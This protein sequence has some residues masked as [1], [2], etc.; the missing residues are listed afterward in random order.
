MTLYVHVQSGVVIK[1]GPSVTVPEVKVPPGQA[2]GSP[3]VPLAF[4]P[5]IQKVERGL[6]FP[7]AP[8]HVLL[9]PVDLLSLLQGLLH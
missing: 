4:V 7:Q 5:A 9:F 1:N 6:Q 3:T 8:P 2:V